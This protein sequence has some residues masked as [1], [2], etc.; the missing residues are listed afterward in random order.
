M[1]AV[2]KLYGPLKTYAG[3]QAQVSLPAGQSV[4]QALE[5][6]GVPAV[7]VALVVV[8]EDPQ[9]KDY[10]LQHGDVVKVMAVLGGG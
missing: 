8:N 6:V 7:L 1:D 5:S 3:G 9:S 10:V 4:R 2:L